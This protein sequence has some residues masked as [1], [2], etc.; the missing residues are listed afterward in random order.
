MN[1]TKIKTLE[2]DLDF[3]KRRSDQQVYQ[4][5]CFHILQSFA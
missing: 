4:L 1:Q 5:H 2:N 3:Y